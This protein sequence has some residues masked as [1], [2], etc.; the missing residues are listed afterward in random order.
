MAKL[1]PKNKADFAFVQHIAHH[2]SDDGDV[3]PA[4]VLPHGVLF[5][6]GAEGLIRK[7]LLENN[8]IHAII[9][10]PENLFYGTSIPTCVLVSE[11]GA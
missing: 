10:L 3:Q 6:G 5:R 8:L 1:A 7:H 4:V 2:L 11:E 9:G